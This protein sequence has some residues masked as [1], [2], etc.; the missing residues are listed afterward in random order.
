M[1]LLVAMG[2]GPNGGTMTE[3][4]TKV[5]TVSK[6]PAIT[7]ATFTATLPR[8]VRVAKGR[9][10]CAIGARESRTFS[11]A[12]VPAATLGRM[13]EKAL[14][15]W[16]ADTPM[17]SWGAKVANVQKGE[18]N[19][20]GPKASHVLVACRAQVKDILAA[21]DAAKSKVDAVGKCDLD[22]LAE[23]CK[24]QFGDEALWKRI[25]KTAET[26]ERTLQKERAALAQLVTSS[27]T[28]EPEE[29]DTE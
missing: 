11:L 15:N 19:S 7:K 10:G 12:D 4:K 6:P 22:G 18:F 16:L 23:L 3:Y 21:V 13:I 17:D 8:E 5:G 25:H 20:K 2:R 14:D 1:Q 28:A 29:V 9:K 24:A 26:A 27:V